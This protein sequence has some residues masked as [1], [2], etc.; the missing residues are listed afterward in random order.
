MQAK[1]PHRPMRQA[2]FFEI[3]RQSFF[4]GWR[5]LTRPRVFDLLFVFVSWSG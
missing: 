2:G 4:E 3:S 1:N 5:V